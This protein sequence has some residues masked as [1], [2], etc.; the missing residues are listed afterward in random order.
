VDAAGNISDP[1]PAVSVSTLPPVPLS[2]SV[3][4]SPNTTGAYTVTWTVASGQNINYEIT[5]AT[6]SGFS[7]GITNYNSSGLSLNVTGRANGTY[8]YRVRACN[9]AG[10]SGYA[11]SSSITVAIP[12]APQVFVDDVTM[13]GAST[14]LPFSGT[15]GISAGGQV[16]ISSAGGGLSVSGPAHAFILVPATTINQYQVRATT[17]SCVNGG[18]TGP[19]DVGWQT[20]GGGTINWKVSVSQ[21]NRLVNCSF[22]IEVSAIANPTVILDS[23]VIRI[24]LDT[25][26]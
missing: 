21:F 26:L 15:Y 6:D 22:R 1:S 4:G 11:Y 9:T 7:T 20:L 23:G 13:E 14:T 19:F 18:K 8:Y 17:L 10:C 2:V 24:N 5:E 25:T 12:S 3:P 16:L